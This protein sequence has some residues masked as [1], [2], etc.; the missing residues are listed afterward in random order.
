[1]LPEYSHETKADLTVFTAIVDATVSEKLFKELNR[2]TS[3][4]PPRDLEYSLIYVSKQ[5]LAAWN[6]YQLLQKTG[7]DEYD[8]CWKNEQKHHSE[9]PSA[10]RGLRADL[11][12]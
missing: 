5:T 8:R 11:D 2:C 3:K 9:F 4:N 12:E 7:K 1:M 10:F 6:V